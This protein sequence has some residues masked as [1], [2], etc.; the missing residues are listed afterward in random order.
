MLKD[1][2]YNTTEHIGLAAVSS[3]TKNYTFTMKFVTN[4]GYTKGIYIYNGDYCT[5]LS[6]SRA[7]KT[8]FS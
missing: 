2:L 4:E 7:L 8:N 6:Q 5:K 3:T 1:Y